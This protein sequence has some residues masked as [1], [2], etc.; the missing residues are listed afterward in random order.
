MSNL[1]SLPTPEWKLI[2]DTSN[3]AHTTCCDHA[4]GICETD[5]IVNGYAMI[6]QRRANSTEYIVTCVCD[7]C[8]IKWMNSRMNLDEQ[9]VFGVQQM[10]CVDCHAPVSMENDELHPLPLLRNSVYTVGVIFLECGGINPDITN[11]R[12]VTAQ[13]IAREYTGTGT[14]EDP[15]MFHPSR[16]NPDFVFS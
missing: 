6:H 11:Q 10:T 16:Q 8:Y 2:S 13:A 5:I 9:N 15:I 7:T 1:S 4:C 14:K 12:M 3:T